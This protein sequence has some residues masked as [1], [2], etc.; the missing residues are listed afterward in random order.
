MSKKWLVPGVLLLSVNAAQAHELKPAT[1]SLRTPAQI[2]DESIQTRMTYSHQIEAKIGKAAQLDES[3]LIPTPSPLA[4]EKMSSMFSVRDLGCTLTLHPN[5]SIADLEID[6]RASGSAADKKKALD[7]IRSAAPFPSFKSSTDL[8]YC[9][10][11][12]LLKVVANPRKSS[13]QE[14]MAGLWTCYRT[15]GQKSEDVRRTSYANQIEKRIGKAANI[16]ESDLNSSTPSQRAHEQMR[17]MFS[18]RHL[19]CILTLQPN[20][21]ISD[22]KIDARASGSDAANK[23]A[24]DLIRAAGPFPAFESS[25]KLSYLV[26]VPSLVVMPKASD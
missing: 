7:L 2:V 10:G 3:D 17:S 4:R 18:V 1:E 6:G 15:P 24:L 16:D 21:V 14:D 12:P 9:V 25:T 20:G 5:G 23:K 13:D 11:V 22:L 26:D 19:W 8:S